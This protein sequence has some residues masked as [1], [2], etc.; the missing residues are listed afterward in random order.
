MQLQGETAAQ[1]ALRGIDYNQH[2]MQAAGLIRL[3]LGRHF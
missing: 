1:F 2:K 3:S